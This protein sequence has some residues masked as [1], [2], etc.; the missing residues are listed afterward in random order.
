MGKHVVMKYMEYCQ[1]GDLKAQGLVP[2][3]CT[4]L[5]L[6]PEERS[7]VQTPMLPKTLMLINNAMGGSGSW[8]RRA[9]LEKVVN[10][11]R[12]G[13]ARSD[14]DVAGPSLQRVDSR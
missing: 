9:P 8:F 14:A 3:I 7:V 2:V 10:A 12:S 1:S 13:G 4:L 5:K 6:S 11:T